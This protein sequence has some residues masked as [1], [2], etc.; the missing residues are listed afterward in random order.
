MIKLWEN[1]L[2]ERN[3]LTLNETTFLGKVTD[4]VDEILKTASIIFNEI[5]DIDF[6]LCEIKEH[7]VNFIVENIKN[8]HYHVLPLKETIIELCFVHISVFT[9][10]AIFTFIQDVCKESWVDFSQQT[11]IEFP[12]EEDI[13]ILFTRLKVRTDKQTLTKVQNNIKTLKDLIKNISAGKF[14]ESLLTR[15]SET[16]PQTL[17]KEIR[18]ASIISSFADDTL[19]ERLIVLE[20]WCSNILDLMSDL[21][22][23][24]ESEGLVEP[25]TITSIIDLLENKPELEAALMYS[26]NII[27]SMLQ[28]IKDHLFV[29]YSWAELVGD[30]SQKVSII[31]LCKELEEDTHARFA[32][33]S[34]YFHSH[35]LRSPV[36]IEEALNGVWVRNTMNKYLLNGFNTISEILTKGLRFFAAFLKLLLSL[37]DRIIKIALPFIQN[38]RPNW[39]YQNWFDIINSNNRPIERM[40]SSV[41]M[42]VSS[43]TQINDHNIISQ[44]LQSIEKP[45]LIQLVLLLF[46][47]LCHDRPLE[48]RERTKEEMTEY[49]SYCF[50]GNVEPVDE[51]L[52]LLLQ[53]CLPTEENFDLE[54]FKTG[55]SHLFN[56][57]MNGGIKDYLFGGVSTVFSEKKVEQIFKLV[58]SYIGFT[59][60]ENDCKMNRWNVLGSLVHDTLIANPHGSRIEAFLTNSSLSMASLKQYLAMIRDF[61][62]Y[63]K[64]GELNENSWKKKILKNLEENP[65]SVINAIING[66]IQLPTLYT[67]EQSVESSYLQRI[68]NLILI[69]FQL[70][71]KELE[72][73][74]SLKD[75]VNSKGPEQERVIQEIS[76]TFNNLTEQKYFTD[77]EIPLVVQDLR[78]LLQNPE[79]EVVLYSDN[80]PSLNYNIIELTE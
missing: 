69:R 14:S 44:V 12:S 32:F 35:T 56:L 57:P 46:D 41:Q 42:S 40:N 55:F 48:L 26:V 60:M 22:G 16:L 19:E 53:D 13:P 78:D 76:S 68:A 67:N 50:D 15:L 23:I 37:M 31:K 74:D 38:L 11:E 79:R 24:L 8:K 65:K 77:E 62:A 28:V 21:Q 43:N 39:N 1:S 73:K 59:S 18:N 70:L 72:I 27:R 75:L 3:K 34:V 10:N 4:I 9:T 51:N 36:F 63:S 25:F 5:L 61:Q 17:H 6:D 7:L 71:E 58:S 47:C 45:L 54:A 80:L 64:S 2:K 30:P 20:F 49:F 33:A 66:E 29:L 52:S